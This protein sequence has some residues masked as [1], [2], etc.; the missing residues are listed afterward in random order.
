MTNL[1]VQRGLEL[2]LL[3]TTIDIPQDPEDRAIIDPMIDAQKAK[4]QAFVDGASVPP[5][6]PT[7]PTEWANYVSSTS[8]DLADID[9]AVSDALDSAVEI[10]D[11]LVADKAAVQADEALYLPNT[12]SEIDTVIQDGKDQ[13][14]AFLATIP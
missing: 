1:Q 5:A 9:L 13:L 6:N 7:P 2:N 4:L 12:V 14:A 11:D 10:R 3:K 8:G